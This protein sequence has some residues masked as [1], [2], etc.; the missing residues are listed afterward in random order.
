LEKIAP[1]ETETIDQCRAR[2][3]AGNT[4]L[5][6]KLSNEKLVTRWRLWVPENWKQMTQND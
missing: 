1:D 2:L 4:K 5:D 6:P 3:T